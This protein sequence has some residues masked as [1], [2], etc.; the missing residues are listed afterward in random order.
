MFVLICICALDPGLY[1][2][3]KH[4]RFILGLLLYLTNETKKTTFFSLF[5]FIFN[6]EKK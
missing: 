2:N 1:K 4:V 3:V 6:V 5:S